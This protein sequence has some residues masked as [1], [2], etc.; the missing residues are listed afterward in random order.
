M[1]LRKPIIALVFITAIGAA[2]RIYNL[3]FK[4]LWVDEALLFQFANGNIDHVL[5]Q[6][7]LYNS[8]PPLF[9]VLLHAILNIG[10]SEWILRLIP[11]LAG[12][13][14]IPV[15]YYLARNFVTHPFALF[16]AL[17]VALSPNQIMYSQQVV[18]YS[19]T[20]LLA[21]VMLCMFLLFLRRA[22][23]RNSLLLGFV[24]FFSIWTHYGLAILCLA[25]NIVF[26]IKIFR[27]DRPRRVLGLWLVAQTLGLLAV[28]GVYHLSLKHQFT[29]G[30]FGTDYLHSGYWDG[31]FQNLLS[32]AIFNTRDIFAF[33]FPL[34]Y[35]LI[36]FAIC[37]VIW[38]AKSKNPIKAT[39]LMALLVPF[40]VTFLFAMARLYPYV[41]TR[42]TIFLLPMLYVFV[43]IGLAYLFNLKYIRHVTL[44]LIAIVLF[45]GVKETVKYLK[46]GDIEDM[47]AIVS[48]LTSEMS[49]DDMK[50]ITHG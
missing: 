47:R 26:F 44:I 50:I 4:S 46:S 3:G 19:L 15:M 33:A 45:Q 38:L 7:A 27:L 10:T 36:I 40:A 41:S 23:W 24:I 13:V 16:A 20:F 9:A 6:N 28:Y 31:S 5:S 42:Q 49:K 48:Q 43:A 17:L 34:G 2:L 30:G 35:L 18:A 37:G 1:W 22:T 14:A 12:I 29:P 21:Q 25:I 11:C 8:Y 39:A 32:I